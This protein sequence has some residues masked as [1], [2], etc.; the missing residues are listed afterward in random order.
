MVFH[1]FNTLRVRAETTGLLLNRTRALPLSGLG[2]GLFSLG[3]TSP[4]SRES[5]KLTLPVLFSSQ[6][7]GVPLLVRQ[8]FLPCLHFLGQPFLG[9]L[10]RNGPL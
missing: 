1:A 9:V 8:S 3:I 5:A 7:Q 10:F 6:K 4:F 2:P